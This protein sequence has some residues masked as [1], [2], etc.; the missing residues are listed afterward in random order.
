MRRRGRTH[1]RTDGVDDGVDGFRHGGDDSDWATAASD[2]GGRDGEAKWSL[3]RQ[4]CCWER[5]SVRTGN[6]GRRVRAAARDGAVRTA[7]KPPSA[8]EH[9]HQ[10][11]P[12]GAR[13]GATLSLTGGPDTDS[14]G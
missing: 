14:G 1:R 2:S 3:L 10:Q 9:R 5:R 7:F 8:F 4:Q 12:I 13:H 11:Q 6:A